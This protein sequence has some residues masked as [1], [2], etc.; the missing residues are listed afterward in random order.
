[1]TVGVILITHANVGSVLLQTAIDVYGACSLN[2]KAVAAP[3]DC[4][5][6]RV[7]EDL[8][9]AAGEMDSGDGVLVLT[10]LFGATPS[11][12]ACRLLNQHQIRVVS[13]LNL[14]MLLRILNYPRLSLDEMEQ[15]AVSGGRDGVQSCGSA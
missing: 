12:I 3:S 14:P 4:N 11:N 1:M 13:G 10:D 8:R 6:E 2:V 7:L 5:P 9:A 15:K